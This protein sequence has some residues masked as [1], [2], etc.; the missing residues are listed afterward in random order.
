M[1]ILSE[2]EKIHGFALKYLN[3]YKNPSQ[4]KGFE[5]FE[6]NFGEECFA[7]GFKMDLGKSFC[8]KFDSKAVWEVEEFEKISY[9]ITDAKFLGTA[10][11]SKWRHITHWLEEFPFENKFRKWF[12]SAFQRLTEITDKNFLQ[13]VECM[14]DKE[15]FENYLTTYKKNF[16][17][18]YLKEKYNLW[19]VVKCF[20]D[21]WNIETENFS[22]MLANSLRKLTATN[23]LIYQFATVMLRRFAENEPEKVYEMFVNLYDEKI[24]ICERFEKFK[25]DSEILFEKYR[26]GNEQKHSQDERAISVYLWLRYPEKYYIYKLFTFDNAVKNL[27]SDYEFIQGDYANNIRKC[28]KFGDEICEELKKDVELVEKLKNNLD[29]DCYSDENLKVLTTDFIFY[30]GKN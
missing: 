9:Q 25:S 15:V 6:E 28:Y 16:S 14:F 17:L 12:I 2:I 29:E 11:C 19:E 21:N 5:D 24:D 8:E 27:K 18:N 3:L 13:E 20:Q 26:R 23:N 10:I 7:L 30:I 22:E 1:K 4:A